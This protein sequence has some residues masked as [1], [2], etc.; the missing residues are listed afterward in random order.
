M[1]VTINAKGTS[2]STFAVGKNGLTLSQAGQIAPPDGNDLTVSLAENTNL[3]VDAGNTGPALI[4]ASDN[5]DLHIN[6]AVGGGQ[7]LVL[8]ETRWPTTD[9][10]AD[11]V[12]TTDGNGVLVF[13]NVRTVGS[14]APAT[15]ATN[16]FA[17]IPKMTGQPTGTP[18]A[19]TGYAPMVFDSVNGRLW[20]Y[21][22]VAWVYSILLAV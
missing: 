2:V 10:A 11:Q 17:Y 5:Q 21:N 22:G 3:V 6:P 4:T 1:A 12:L 7:Y 18:S 8:G 20:V 19:V 13:A 9:G 15:T 14:P 16:G